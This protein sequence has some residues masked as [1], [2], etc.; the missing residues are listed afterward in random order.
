MTA[1]HRVHYDS[2]KGTNESNFCQEIGEFHT[3]FDDDEFLE[4][5]VGDNFDEDGDDVN[6][7]DAD[8]EMLH[9]TKNLTHFDLMEDKLWSNVLKPL[10]TGLDVSLQMIRSAKIFAK[11]KHEA[12]VLYSFLLAF[13]LGKK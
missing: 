4:F 1:T 6:N 8:D 2:E 12:K 5:R 9:A 10:E 3:D 13:L 11:T 7:D